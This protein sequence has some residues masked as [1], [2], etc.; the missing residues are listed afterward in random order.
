MIESSQVFSGLMYKEC[1][2]LSESDSLEDIHDE[3]ER[4][5]YEGGLV[6]RSS[7]AFL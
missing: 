4:S 5:R 7:Q 1:N 2:C 3:P 6:V